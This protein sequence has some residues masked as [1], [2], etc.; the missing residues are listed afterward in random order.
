MKHSGA[1]TYTQCKQPVEGSCQIGV[2]FQKTIMIK[3]VSVSKVEPDFEID[4]EKHGL[5]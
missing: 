4:F 2:G 3:G 1:I 5:C